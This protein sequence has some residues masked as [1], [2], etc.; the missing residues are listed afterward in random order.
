MK[1]WSNDINE[2]VKNLNEQLKQIIMI[3]INLKEIKIKEPPN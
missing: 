3:G 1:N 2:T